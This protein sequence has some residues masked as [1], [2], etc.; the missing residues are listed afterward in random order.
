MMRQKAVWVAVCVGAGFLGMG[1][2]VGAL[3]VYQDH[4]ALHGV[5]ALIEN[6]QR[7]QQAQVPK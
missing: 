6:A 7:Q 4:Q 3:H 2:A 1:L 5:I